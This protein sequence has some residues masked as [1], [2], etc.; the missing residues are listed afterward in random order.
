MFHKFTKQSFQNAM[1]KTQSFMGTA[2]H[3]TKSFLGHVDHGVKTAKKIYAI[4]EPSISHF[5]G[6]TRANKMNQGI[7]KAVTTYDDIKHQVV[8]HH[9]TIENHVRQV[10][11]KFKKA[12]LSIGME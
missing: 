2:Y 7:M 6:E 3:H 12:G 5:A 10:G 11:N 1:N 8:N 4:L 9:D